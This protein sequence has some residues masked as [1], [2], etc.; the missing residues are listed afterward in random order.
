MHLPNA[1]IKP[2]NERGQ[3]VLELALIMPVLVMLVFGALEVGRLLNAWVVVTEA[4]REGARVAAAKCT[5]Q[6]GCG[7]LVQ[8]GVTNS[9]AGL[10]VA[11]SSWSMTT[12]PYVAGDAVTVNVDYRSQ[13]VVP[14]ISSIFGSDEVTVHSQ[15]S[16]RLE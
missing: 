8:T 3:A 1:T 9:L 11:R 2:A 10:D 6:A 15:T 7:T 12:G 14:L 5:W 4:S 13:L 16:M